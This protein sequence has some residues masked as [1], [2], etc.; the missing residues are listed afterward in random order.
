MF[1][2]GER[3]AVLSL[4]PGNNTVVSWELLPYHGGVLQL[5][6]IKL[7]GSGDTVLHATQN[8]TI[9]VKHGAS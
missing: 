5:P 9:V 7:V 3:S 6:E 1:N 2:A 4:L 8:Y